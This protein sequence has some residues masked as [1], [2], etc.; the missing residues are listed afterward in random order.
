MTLNTE[1]IIEGAF[2]EVCPPTEAVDWLRRTRES[3]G[4]K[5]LLL[6]DDNKHQE[7]I[8]YLRNDAFIEFGLAR[9]GVAS[10]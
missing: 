6:R 4:K 7:E 2:L 10:C 9:Y 3:A 1:E 5:P 8:P